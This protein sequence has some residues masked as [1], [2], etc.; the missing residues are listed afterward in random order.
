MG[1]C[2]SYF[3]CYQNVN[4]LF[5]ALDFCTTS[6]Q[7][8]YVQYITDGIQGVV[9]RFAEVEWDQAFFA[10][11]LALFCLLFALGFYYLDRMSAIFNQRWRHTLSDYAVPISVAP[12]IWISYSAKDQVEVE[13]ISLP[14]NF[15]PTYPSYD[16][17]MMQMPTRT[18][19]IGTK[20][21]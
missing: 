15:E 5:Y 6:M 2:I 21:L 14:R 16:E 17:D 20:V 13:R 12:C 8:S 18:N 10:F 1:W 3:D 11:F 7:P 9:E 4:T 19:A